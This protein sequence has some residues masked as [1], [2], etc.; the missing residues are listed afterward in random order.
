MTPRLGGRGRKSAGAKARATAAAFA[1]VTVVAGLSVATSPGIAGA[2]TTTPKVLLVGTYHG[3]KGQYT[4]VQKAVDAA[5]PGDWILVAPGDYHEGAHEKGPTTNQASRGDFGGLLINTPNIHLRGM[6]RSTT[7]IDGTKAGSPECS[8]TKQNQNFGANKAGRNGI[9][10]YKADNVSIQN[11]TVCNF[12]AGKGSSGN[13][14]WWNGG[15]DSGKIGLKGYSGSYL[16]ATST[17]F[18]GESTAATYGIFSSNATTGTWNEIYASNFNDSGMYIGACQRSC[19]ATVDNA[20]MEYNALGYSGTNSGGRLVVENSQFDQNEDGFDTNTQISGDPPAPQ[21]GRC[22]NT[23]MSP[24]T[25]TD[26]CWVFMHNNVHNNNN[27][28]VPAAGNASGG[29]TGTGMTVSGGHYDTVMDNTF[30][31]NGAWGTLF[32]P[33]PTSGTPTLGQKCTKVTGKE[34]KTLGLGCVFD[35]GGN[36]LVNN[37]YSHNG[38]FGNPSNGDYGQIV[39]YSGGPMNCYGGNTAPDGSAPANLQTTQPLATCGQPMKAANDGGTLL[40]QALCDTGFGSCPAG[41]SY[42]KRAKVVMHPLPQ[43]STM[44]NPCKGVPANAWCPSKSS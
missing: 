36:A 24:I 40:G 14:I 29:P 23:T 5:S 8:A 11:L 16:T 7:V 27:P 1:A 10:V 13:A 20:W 19:T 26:S 2:G 32:V 18:G 37:T 4:T 22:K 25:H 30:A 28:T 43:L 34:T 38:F 3:H 33:Y 9:V 42:P 12:L 44:P 17:Y 39:L 6:D 21:T 41:A 31:T 15:A 35:P